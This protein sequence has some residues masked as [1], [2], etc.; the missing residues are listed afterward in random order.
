MS[1]RYIKSDYVV[2]IFY[3]IFA[4]SIPFHGF[5]KDIFGINRFE[6]KLTMITFM[7]MFVV[8][9]YTFKI[10]KYYIHK[11]MYI[12]YIMVFIYV[13]SL[14]ISINNSKYPYE[15]F[16]QSIVITCLVTMMI[17]SGQL[18][19]N[20][21]TIH[22][23]FITIG[24]TCFIISISSLFVHYFYNYVPRLGQIGD[25]RL[26]LSRGDPTYFGDIILYGIGSVYYIIILYCRKMHSLILSI[27]T[28]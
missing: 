21:N 16:T 6:I 17:V 8:W 23:V 28:I 3:I 22:Y 27:P 14:Y 20:N 26:S 1:R 2:N 12:I 13:I 10:Y 24:V 5:E 9:L 19:I 25:I 18:V 4:A 7:I 15:S 11:N